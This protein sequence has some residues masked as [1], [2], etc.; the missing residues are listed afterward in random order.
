M[1]V[2]ASRPVRRKCGQPGAGLSAFRNVEIRAFAPHFGSFFVGLNT[3]SDVLILAIGVYDLITR[4]RLAP[5]YGPAVIWVL[6]N[7]TAA[8]WLYF[9]PAWKVLATRIAGY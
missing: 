2:A 8:S 6:A 3:G 9:N 7:E 1:K 5:A 4:G